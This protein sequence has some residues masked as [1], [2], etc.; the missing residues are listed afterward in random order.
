[1]KQQ[2]DP[3]DASCLIPN[4]NNPKSVAFSRWIHIDSEILLFLKHEINV[5]KKYTYLI[6]LITSLWII[7]ILMSIRKKQFSFSC[8]G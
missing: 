5:T 6:F 4:E 8:G 1:M 7:Y 2:S 3:K